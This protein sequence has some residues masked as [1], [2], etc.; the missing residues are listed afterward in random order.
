MRP[1]ATFLFASAVVLLGAGCPR[2]D[3]ATG[4]ATSSSSSASAVPGAAPPSASG[5]ASAIGSAVPT[6]SSTAGHRD[7]GD[8]MHGPPVVLR[9]SGKGEG[10]TDATVVID[11]EVLIPMDAPATLKVRLPAG[12]SLTSGKDTES[13]SVAQKGTLHR[14]LQVKGA[15]PVTDAAPID[16]SLEAR[17]LDAGVGF[18][19]ERTWPPRTE[20][21]VPPSSGPR[22][23]MGRPPGPAPTPSAP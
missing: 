19:A 2:R 16:V 22:P 18:H 11:I 20:M 17:D 6:T 9:L 23:P 13:L 4:P 3:D 21:V 8:G 12:A 10:T 1:A 7:A 5:V 14:Q 15:S